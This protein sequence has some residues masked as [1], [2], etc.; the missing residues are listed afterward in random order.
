MV[1]DITNSETLHKEAD[2]WIKDV[3]ANAPAH[4]I[5]AL[6]GNKSDLYEKKQVPLQELQT[7]ASRNHIDLYNE[8]SAM[9]NTG[10]NE[11]F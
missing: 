3:K 4:L 8:T 6:A 7:Y 10:I 5:L 2:Y 11:I 9:N 1:Y